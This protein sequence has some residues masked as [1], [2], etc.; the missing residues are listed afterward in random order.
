MNQ[1][2]LAARRG[3]EWLLARLNPDGSLRG[4]TNLSAYYKT[5]CALLW[6]GHREEAVGMLRYVRDRFLIASGDLD[7]SGVPWL[8]Q[9]RIYPHAWLCCGALEAGE[10]QI[11]NQLVRF[12]L[13]WRDEQSGG[14]R[15]RLDGTQ[16][17]M[18]TSIAGLAS[19]RAGLVD[20]AEGV[21]RWLDRV[22]EQQPDL[23]GA[24]YHVWHP[25]SG[26]VRGDGSAAYLVN[27]DQP[28]QW[29]FMYG[30]S[31]AFLTEYARVTGDR[32]ALDLGRRYLHASRHCF[33]D[34]YLTPQSGKLGWGAAWMY[35]L[36]QD[37]EDRAIVEAVVQGLSALQCGDGTWNAQGVYE[38][39]PTSEDDSRFDVTAEFVALLAPMGAI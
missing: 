22:M 36:T 7:G 24:L 32:R 31:A 6:N 39:K 33:E 15:A 5:P 37:P 20:V 1:A 9:Y 10:T 8:D 21:V 38:E 18:T 35:Q 25:D 2:Q 34:R 4:A 13:S 19:L 30:I 12:L 28:R 23:T 3:A 16:E 17:I 29:Y 14:F 27:T 26:L 11:A